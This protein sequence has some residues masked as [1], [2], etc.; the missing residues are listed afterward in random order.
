MFVSALVGTAAFESGSAVE[1]DR[2]TGRR[3]LPSTLGGMGDTHG[4]GS[5][6]SWGR[7]GCPWRRYRCCRCVRAAGESRSRA[8]RGCCGVHVASVHPTSAGVGTVLS[9]NPCRSHGNGRNRLSPAASSSPALQRSSTN[10]ESTVTLNHAA[11]SAPETTTVDVPGPSQI[12]VTSTRTDCGRFA[13][14]RYTSRWRGAA[15]PGRPCPTLL[16]RPP[17]QGVARGG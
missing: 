16:V 6:D 15:P 10:L 1:A 9:S 12:V 7:C 3:R 14:D 17:A 11:R 8:D 2:R 4:T 13:E 5:A